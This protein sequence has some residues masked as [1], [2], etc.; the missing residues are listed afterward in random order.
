MAWKV[1]RSKSC[2]AISVRCIAVR[3][4]LVYCCL[5]EGTQCSLLVRVLSATV[6]AS[7]RCLHSCASLPCASLIDGN[8]RDVPWGDVHLCIYLVRSQIQRCLWKQCM[9]WVPLKKLGDHLRVHTESLVLETKQEPTT[10]SSVAPTG[11]GFSSDSSI[12]NYSS[13]TLVI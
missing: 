6:L 9:K 2:N 3:Y 12:T 13:R 7:R 10:I 1:A 8:Q 5:Y 11:Y 4:I